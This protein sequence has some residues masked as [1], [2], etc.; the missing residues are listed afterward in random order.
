MHKDIKN[1]IT[2]NP[3]LKAVFHSLTF[4]LVSRCAL[5]EVIMSID[6]ASVRHRGVYWVSIS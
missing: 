5:V 2:G 6:W 3:V 4:F 1:E